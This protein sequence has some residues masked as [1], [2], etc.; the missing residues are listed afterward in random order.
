MIAVIHSSMKKNNVGTL[1]RPAYL[2]LHFLGK[3]HL[4]GS[5]FIGNSWVT[6]PF[7]LTRAISRQGG[8]EAE[9]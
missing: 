3:M 1:F 2:H 7:L 5:R 8:I 6:Q 4:K 9:R